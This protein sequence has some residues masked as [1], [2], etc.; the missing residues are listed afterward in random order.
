MANI[1]LGQSSCCVCT[2]VHCTYSQACILI[3][4]GKKIVQASKRGQSYCILKTGKKIV[5]ASSRLGQSQDSQARELLLLSPTA[6][7]L[8][9]PCW[10]KPKHSHS[11]VTGRRTVKSPSYK[12][13]KMLVKQMFWNLGYLMHQYR[14][15]TTTYGQSQNIHTQARVS[16]VK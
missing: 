3:V 14:P 1:G 15:L 12:E 16:L 6:A 4:Y 2:T 11:T 8:L 5:Q 9:V 10:A 7:A 13:V